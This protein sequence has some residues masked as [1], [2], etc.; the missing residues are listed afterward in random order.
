ML[1]GQ[2]GRVVSRLRSQRAEFKSRPLTYGPV[3][4]DKLPGPR[5]CPDLRNVRNPAAAGRPQGSVSGGDHHSYDTKR[6]TMA[7]SRVFP[8]VCRT[9]RPEPALRSQRA[10][11]K[12]GG[13]TSL[14]DTP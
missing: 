3:T 13:H 14:P 10:A 7:S 6:V 1:G 9:S 2:G 4:L 8:R 11:Q 12:R 5:K